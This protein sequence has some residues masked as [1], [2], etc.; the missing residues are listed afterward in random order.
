MG[1]NL[2]CQ[3][4]KVAGVRCESEEWQTYEQKKLLTKGQRTTEQQQKSIKQKLF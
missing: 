1:S 4:N 2:S 3:V